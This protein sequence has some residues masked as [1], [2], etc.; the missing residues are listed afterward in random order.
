MVPKRNRVRACNHQFLID[1]LCD[2]ET[3]IHGVLAIDDAQIDP[4]LRNAARKMGPDRVTAD[5]PDNVTDEQNSHVRFPGY[6]RAAPHEAGT[7]AEG[8]ETCWRRLR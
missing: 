1:R 4:P 5:L 3:L 8:A 6:E 7:H 2:A